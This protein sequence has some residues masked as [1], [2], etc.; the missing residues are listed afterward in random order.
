MSVD[1]DT[2]PVGLDA[3]GDMPGLS[4]IV[5][6]D[7][8]RALCGEDLADYD[9]IGPDDEIECVV[10]LDLWDQYVTCGKPFCR[11]RQ[12]WRARWSRRAEPSPEVKR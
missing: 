10:C 9:W 4:H 5:C 11:T 3:E 1:V 2:Q 8:F 6:C 12:W 7:P